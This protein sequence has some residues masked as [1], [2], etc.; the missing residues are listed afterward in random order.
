MGR[1]PA[2][3]R[4]GDEVARVAHNYFFHAQVGYCEGC[5]HESRVNRFV[6]ESG[7]SG[8]HVWLCARCVNEGKLPDGYTVERW[9]TVCEGTIPEFARVEEAA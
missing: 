6:S 5:E 2:D 8:G 4:V 1:A 3:A 7:Y 9:C